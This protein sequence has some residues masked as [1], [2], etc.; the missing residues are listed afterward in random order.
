MKRMHN[1]SAIQAELSA[2]ERGDAIPIELEPA[3]PEV[4]VVLKEVREAIRERILLTDEASADDRLLREEDICIKTRTLLAT[5]DSST[6]WG[7]KIDEVGRRN[8]QLHLECA[9]CV[10]QIERACGDEIRKARQHCRDSVKSRLKD[11]RDTD[12]LEALY[13]ITSVPT[14]VPG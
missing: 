13:T 7:G 12:R 5:F 9:L 2:I 14:S 10:M 11:I 6:A 4:Y 8:T 3:D 1:K